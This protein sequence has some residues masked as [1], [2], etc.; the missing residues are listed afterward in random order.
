MPIVTRLIRILI[1]AAV[2][3]SMVS[4]GPIPRRE[5]AS[6]ST[7]RTPTSTSAP[8][9]STLSESMPTLTAVQSTVPQDPDLDNVCRQTIREYF[10]VPCGDWEALR[11]LHIPS[12]QD[13]ITPDSWTCNVA[14]SKTLLS[15]MS[16][17]EWWQKHS[18]QPLPRSAYPTQPNEYVYYVEYEIKW[19]PG[20]V[21]AREN[22]LAS[23]IWMVADENGVCKI[24]AQGW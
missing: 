19:A 20:V 14:I 23:L 18:E 24:R 21:P 10:A 4:C 22:P 15:L 7:D 11:A 17:S 12:S 6:S 5:D 16:A 2:S 9:L 8:I 3:V 13:E 1:F